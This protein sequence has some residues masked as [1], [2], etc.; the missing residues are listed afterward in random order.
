MQVGSWAGNDATTCLGHH[1]ISDGAYGNPG[2][3]TGDYGDPN[4][5]TWLLCCGEAAQPQWLSD[6]SAPAWDGSTWGHAV[7][8]CATQ[9]GGAM[10]LCWAR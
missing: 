4:C 2:W 3:G 5:H 9:P 8:Y 10:E 7:D 6:E 1:E